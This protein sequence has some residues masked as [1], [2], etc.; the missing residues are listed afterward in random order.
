MMFP[1]CSQFCSQFCSYFKCFVLLRVPTVPSMCVS[2]VYMKYTVIGVWKM[3]GNTGN[4]EHWE[5][6][7]AAPRSSADNLKS[8]GCFER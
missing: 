3:G 7:R 5:H 2:R 1:V 6:G 4:W 8:N